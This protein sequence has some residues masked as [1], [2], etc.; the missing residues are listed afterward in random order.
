MAVGVAVCSVVAS[1]A[2]VAV[3]PAGAG[4]PALEPDLV[5]LPFEA[6]DFGMERKGKRTLLSF[7]NEIGNKGAG[8]LEITPSEISENC[9]GDADPVNDRSAYQRVYGDSD[10]DGL[11]DGSAEPVELEQ[12]F[13][14]MRYH[15]IHDHWHVLDF[16]RYELRREPAGGLALQARKAGFCVYD[17]RLAFPGQ[18]VPGTP[19]YPTGP[20]EQTQL[21]GC[22]E[23]ETQGLSPGWADVYLLNV[24]G[25]Q[26]DVTALS[27]GIY[28]LR[29]TVDPLDLLAE[30]DETNNATSVRLALRPRLLSVRITRRPCSKAAAGG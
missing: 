9:D 15:P 24:P 23:A 30:R 26:L 14:C 20:S 12:M 7:S 5:T 29:S 18:G 8:P 17:N 28:C 25:Q 3:T 6:G 1:V 4:S 22:Q 19:V 2:V 21:R 10:A 13:G 16:A 11:Y 27:R